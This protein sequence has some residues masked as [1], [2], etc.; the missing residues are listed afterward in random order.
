MASE[1]E[2][3]KDLLEFLVCLQIHTQNQN[4]LVYW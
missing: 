2:V 4:L 3:S 1:L